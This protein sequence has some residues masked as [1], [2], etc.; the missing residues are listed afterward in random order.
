MIDDHVHPFP[1]EFA[2]FDSAE[3]GLDVA[4]GPAA[5]ARRRRLAPGRLYLHL[6]ENRL[7]GWLGVAVEDVAAARDEAARPDWAG[8]LHRLLDDAE[9]TGMVL[10]EAL[11]PDDPAQ[12]TT[13]YEELHRPPGLEDGPARP[14]GRP[15]GRSGRG[16]V[17]TSS[18]PWRPSWPTRRPPA[19]SPSRPC[20]PTGR[21]WRSTPTP[22]WR[23]PSGH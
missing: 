4:P 23:P 1:L 17:R 7:A 14:A 6:L 19:P 22:T 2:P 9:L 10:D 21:G 3:L 12:P 5:A 11:H 18:P 20:S 8:Y 16:G 15:A 13:V